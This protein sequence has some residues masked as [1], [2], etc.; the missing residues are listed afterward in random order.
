MRKET[1]HKSRLRNKPQARCSVTIST[2]ELL[3]PASKDVPS[4]G[5][6]DSASASQG[7]PSS[8]ET[9]T[10]PGSSGDHDKTCPP[11]KTVTEEQTDESPTKKPKLDL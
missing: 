7:A 11:T 8:V 6:G 1:V 2:D 9:A 3:K 10:T 4:Q 5:A